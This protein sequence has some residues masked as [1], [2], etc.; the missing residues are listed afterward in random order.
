MVGDDRAQAV[1]DKIKKVN[2]DVKAYAYKA[3]VS[4]EDEVIGMFKKMIEEFGTID[5]LVNNAGLQRDAPFS[6]M[7][8]K[9]NSLFEC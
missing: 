1:I 2:T 5:I 3:D 9:R 4:K 8:L 6:E 7:T